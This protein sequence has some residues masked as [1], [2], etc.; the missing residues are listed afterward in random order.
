[1]SSR[2]LGQCL[3]CDDVAVGINF[4]VPTCA[5]CKAFFRRNAVKLGRR[6]FVCQQ[7]GDCPVTFKSRRFCNCCRL[8]KCFRVG[9]QK[10]LIRSEAEREARKQLVEQNRQKRVQYPVMKT[11]DLIRPSTLLLLSNSQSQCISLSDQTLLTNIFSAYERTCIATKVVQC[12]AFPSSKHSTLHTFLSEYSERQKALVKYFK[13]VP[14]FD[15]LSMTD[16]IR[17]IRNN[18]CFTLPIN[19]ATLSTDI[20]QQLLDSVSVLFYPNISVQLIECIKLVHSYANDRSLLKLLLIIKSLSNGINRYRHDTDM[21][22]IYD[23]SLTIFSA[24]NI[25]VELLWKYLI[26][27]FPSELDVVKFYNKLI[28]DLLFVQR[29]CFIADSYINNLTDE[30]QQME[31]LIQSMWPVP[32]Q[33]NNSDVNDVDMKSVSRDRRR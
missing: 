8:A 20:S 27:R 4:A 7:D 5:A 12:P 24:Q 30:I 18:F 14:E 25:Y 29:V 28:R 32:N 9:M 26:T 23:D 21:N 1:M 17:L 13:L 31:P 16:K 15:R 2:S 22:G 33:S 3:V 6:D 11:S 10:A 19:E